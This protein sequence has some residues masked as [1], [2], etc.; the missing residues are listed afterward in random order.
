MLICTNCFTK[1]RVREGDFY[2]KWL[3]S[4]W[5][6]IWHSRILFSCYQVAVHIMTWHS[7]LCSAFFSTRTHLFNHCRLQH[8]HFSRV[9][10]LPCL[11]DCVCTFQ[12]LGLSTHLSGTSDPQVHISASLFWILKKRSMKQLYSDIKMATLAQM[13]TLQNL[14]QIHL[15]NFKCFFSVIMIAGM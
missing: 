5:H 11:H 6:V 14:A 4:K 10:S 15:V 9:S 2:I 8:S 1:S 3:E 12:T 7:K 13:W